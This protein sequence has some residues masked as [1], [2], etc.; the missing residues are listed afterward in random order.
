[1]GC[2]IYKLCLFATALPLLGAD[3]H[4]PVCMEH[5]SEKVMQ[6]REENFNQ[7]NEGSRVFFVAGDSLLFLP[8]GKKNVHYGELFWGG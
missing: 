7:L 2:L 6:I 3:L 5:S 1:M 4:L 8:Q